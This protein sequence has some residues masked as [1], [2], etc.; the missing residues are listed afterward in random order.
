MNIGNGLKMQ[1]NKVK[2]IT[3][4]FKVFTKTELPSDNIEAYGIRWV[5][6]PDTY[7]P[8]GKFLPEDWQ[9]INSANPSDKA[10]RDYLN[11]FRFISKAFLLYKEKKGTEPIG[12]VWIIYDNY[13]GRS[14]MIHGGT[15]CAGEIFT[16]LLFRGMLAL[17]EH[18]LS[19]GFKVHSQCNI[20]NTRSLRFLRGV[21]F[22]PYR[23]DGNYVRL[24]ITSREIERSEICRRIKKCFSYRRK[25]SMPTDM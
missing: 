2:N 23:Y 19:L 13:L 4:R 1:K 20:E 8:V 7:Q 21:G 12:F 3:S 10:F 16:I 24:Y 15:W 18:L 9:K 5:V 14:V 17:V 6:M 11:S 22:R 25:K